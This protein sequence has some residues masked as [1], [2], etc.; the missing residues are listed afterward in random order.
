MPKA[1]F[2]QAKQIGRGL[3][4]VLAFSEEIVPQT[5]K[6]LADQLKVPS[7][8]NMAAKSSDWT[9]SSLSSGI[10]GLSAQ[11]IAILGLFCEVGPYLLSF[12][13]ALWS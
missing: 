8:S 11:Q 10:T 12:S 3:T 6:Y 1:D 5:W 4:S 7:D 13:R 9:F 2:F